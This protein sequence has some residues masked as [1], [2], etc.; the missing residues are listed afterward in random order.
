MIVCTL[1]MRDPIKIS[2]D[3]S[4]RITVAFSYDPAYVAKVKTI[5]G[6]RWH[7]KEKH[8]SFPYSDGILEKILKVFDG[9][10]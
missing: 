1:H 7:P 2:K 4:G 8:W 5:E 6:Y 10:K 9:K 3:A